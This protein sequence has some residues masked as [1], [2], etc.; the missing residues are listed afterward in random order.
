[1]RHASGCARN[2]GP[3]PYTD[4]PRSSDDKCPDGRN[5]HQRGPREGGVVVPEFGTNIE[6]IDP[7]LVIKEY[8]KPEIRDYGTLCTLTRGVPPG[9]HGDVPRGTTH[10]PVFS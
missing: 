5:H 7:I 4:I 2:V 10:D 6:S 1:C 3:L 8:S 9:Y